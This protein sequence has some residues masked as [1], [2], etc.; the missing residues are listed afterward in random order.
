[1]KGRPRASPSSF[2]AAGVRAVNT[3]GTLGL[4]SRAPFQATLQTS[5]TSIPAGGSPA[6]GLHADAHP[7]LHA[8]PEDPDP[9]PEPRR[10]RARPAGLHA[11]LRDHA[12][13]RAAGPRPAV[14]IE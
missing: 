4:C 9:R 8:T 10:V 11:V 2:P 14:R 13:P 6:R 12:R 1:M 7:P 3:A 5:A